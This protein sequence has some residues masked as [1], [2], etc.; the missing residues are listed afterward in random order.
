MTAVIATAVAVVVA[1]AEVAAAW[2]GTRARPAVLDPVWAA[3]AL[4]P[5]GVLVAVALAGWGWRRHHGA[6]ATIAH[7]GVAT[8]AVGAA[9][10][11]GNSAVRVIAPL[12]RA[13]SAGADTVLRLGSATLFIFRNTNVAD[14]TEYNLGV[15]VRPPATVATASASIAVSAITE[16]LLIA[17]VGRPEMGSN[18]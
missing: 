16:V 11:T 10:G 5:A 8:L 17:S 15:V 2:L 4:L 18:T 6:A 13:V 12:D 3:R 7:L 1:A 14:F 9:L